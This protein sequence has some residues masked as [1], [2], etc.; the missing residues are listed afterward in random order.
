MLPAIDTAPRRRAAFTI[1]E[2]LISSVV[3]SIILVILIGLAD[4]V[5]R[6][7]AQATTKSQAYRETQRAM[8]AISASLSQAT[9]NTYLDYVDSSGQYRFSTSV[10]GTA[11]VP[12]RYVRTSELRFISG[13]DLAGSAPIRP[14]HGIFFQAPLG[15]VSSQAYQ[16]LNNLF[17]SVGFFV[18]FRDDSAGR[19]DYFPNLPHPSPVSWRYRLVQAIQPSDRLT[20]YQFTAGNPGLRSTDANGLQW[21]TDTL[22]STTRVIADNV[23]ALVVL[24]KLGAADQA[25]GG[26]ADDS[27]APDYR[28]DSTGINSDPALNPRNQ[29]PSLLEITLVAVDEKSFARFQGADST[30]RDLGLGNLFRTVGNL[31]DSSQAGYAKDLETLKTTLTRNK[32]DYRV[33]TLTVTINSARWSKEQKN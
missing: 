28:Y 25:A 24:P 2:V 30:P 13:N 22:G 7:H 21:L 33:F 20:I 18:E 6:I 4:S 3:L 19:P 17:N 29:L 11:F 8:E 32:I 15:L 26:Y 16:G 5:R 12:D 1:L 23:I 9:L 31:K 14:T 27:L 10:S